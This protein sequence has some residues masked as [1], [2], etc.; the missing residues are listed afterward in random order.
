MIKTFTIEF[1]KAIAFFLWFGI[2]F[3]LIGGMCVSEKYCGFF[4]ILLLLFAALNYAALKT[5][6]IHDR[7]KEK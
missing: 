5:P 2:L 3:S 4:F 7:N 1:F 6:C